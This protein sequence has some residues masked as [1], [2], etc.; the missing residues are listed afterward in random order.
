MGGSNEPHE[1]EQDDLHWARTRILRL[2][3]CK[4][5][6]SLQVLLWTSLIFPFLKVIERLTNAIISDSRVFNIT[7]S[8]FIEMYNRQS[9]YP[10]S[11]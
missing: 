2:S 7:D 10:S 5:L 9:G 1:K 4:S 8:T 3:G 6:A 11:T